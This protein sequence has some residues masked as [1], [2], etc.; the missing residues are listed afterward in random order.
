MHIIQGNQ[1]GF[2]G[3]D[4]DRLAIKEIGESIRE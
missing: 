1:E 4:N 2:F 3:R